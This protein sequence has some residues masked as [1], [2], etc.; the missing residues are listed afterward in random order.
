MVYFSPK[1][2]EPHTKRA[3]N[4]ENLRLERKKTKKI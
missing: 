1:T 4:S 2:Y 3:R